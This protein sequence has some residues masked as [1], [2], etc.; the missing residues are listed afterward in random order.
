LSFFVNKMKGANA[1]FSHFL[2]GSLVFLLSGEV[3]NLEITKMF[4][5]FGVF[6]ATVSDPISLIISRTVKLNKWSHTHRDNLS[7]SIFF[8]V[9]VLIVVIFFDFKV[10]I[11][12]SVA[13]LTHPLLDLFGIG[14]GVKLFYPYSNKTYKAFYKGQVLVV[15][16]QEEVDALVAKHG[17][18]DWFWN[19][20]LKPNLTIVF[21]GLCLIGAL[22]LVIMN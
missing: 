9:I 20:F 19:I 7:H 16:S 15:W 22:A 3:Y 6:W 12:V 5:M 10:A 14:W 8:S 17:D 4:L 18:D 2:V 11:M 1:M 13:T 21:E